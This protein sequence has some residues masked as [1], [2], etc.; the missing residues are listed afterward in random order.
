MNYLTT[1]R[2]EKSEDLNA[3]E[4][5]KVIIWG[6]SGHA[7]V[8]ADIIRRSTNFEICGFLDDVNQELHGTEF[9]GSLILGGKEQLDN[10]R[11]KNIKNLIVAIG[12]CQVR[13]ELAELAKT[14]GFQLITAIHPQAIVA[15]NAIIGLGSV[16][17][18]GAIIN[19]GAK[20]NA[21]VI[22][23]TSASV[24][25]ECMIEDAVHIGPGVR[26]GGLVNVKQGAWIGIGA[27]VADRVTIGACSIVGAGAVVLRDVPE[28]V[29]VYGVPAKVIRRVESHDY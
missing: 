28:G 27:T 26:L 3:L 10:L 14:K 17:A 18:A 6:A 11:A 2:M 23:N 8:T 25:H 4:K 7:L 5:F 9:C 15:Q 22:I 21:N 12:N 20:I 13:Q 1:E 29:V 16:V 24:D 19:P